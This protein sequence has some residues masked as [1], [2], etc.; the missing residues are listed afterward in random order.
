[1]HWTRKHGECVVKRSLGYKS[2]C[3]TSQPADYAIASRYNVDNQVKPMIPGIT[4]SSQMR[5]YGWGIGE[6]PEV[7]V[8]I[9]GK[10]PALDAIA[11]LHDDIGI[12]R[13][14]LIAPCPR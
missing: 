11:S 8:M 4:D 9:I 5:T 3:S 13:L 12:I 2:H 7:T 10:R 14:H 6:L 1:M